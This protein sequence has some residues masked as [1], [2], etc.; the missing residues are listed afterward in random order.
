MTEHSFSTQYTVTQTSLL[1]PDKHH[2]SD[3]SENLPDNIHP[4]F[5]K[6]CQILYPACPWEAWL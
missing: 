5:Q 1:H 3:V 2:S 4:P 6:T